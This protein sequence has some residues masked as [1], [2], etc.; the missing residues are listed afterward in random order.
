MQKYVV[1]FL[2]DGKGYVALINKTHP[3]WQKGRLN[4]IGGKI[5]DGETPE[6]A[7]RREFYEE[8]GLLLNWDKFAVSKGNNYEVHI[9]KTRLV[10]GNSDI[11]SMTDEKVGW[12]LIDKLPENIIPELAYLIP[13][14][15]YKL[16][17]TAEIFHESE[18]C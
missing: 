16:D 6:V 15:N 9:F 18:T 7:M 12:Y 8:A 2:F 11:R 3:E 14:A 4:G 1:G 10:K 17:I 5:E 13:M